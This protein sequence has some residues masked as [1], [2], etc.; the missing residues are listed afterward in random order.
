MHY[1]IIAVTV[2]VLAFHST[3]A[4]ADSRPGWA[5]KW[6][7]E[8]PAPWTEWQNSLQPKGEAVEI[9][10]S[11]NGTTDYRIIIP[12]SSTAQERR[13]ASELGLWLG[14]ITGAEFPLVTDETE[15]QAREL[16]VGK[17]NRRTPAILAKEI[18]SGLEGY[19]L[20]V[21]EDRLFFLGN[22]GPLNA[23]LAFLEEDLG[24]RWFAGAELNNE[25]REHT[26]A[27]E[28]DPWHTDGAIRFPRN[29]S[30]LASVVPRAKEP[31]IA[32]RRHTW[33]HYSYR[34]LG[35]RNRINGGFD[36]RHEYQ[37]DFVN[38]G[39]GVHTFHRLVPP[40]KYFESNPEYFSLVDGARR[41]RQ[42]QICLSNPEVAEVAAQTA[43]R[44]LRAAPPSHRMIGVSPM[45]WLGNCECENCREL[46]EATGAYSGVLLTFV[47]RVAEL[48]EKE[49]PDATIVTLAY[50]QSR[51][52]PETDI[53]MRDNVAVWLALDRN[54]TFDWP[55]HSFFDDKFSDR[56]VVQATRH[57]ATFSP[58]SE[59]ELFARWKEISP[60]LMLWM[61][62]TQYRNPHAPMPVWH[63]L[64]ENLQFAA[65][66]GVEMVYVQTPGSGAPNESMRAWI[67]AKLLWDP[68][69]DVD[70]LIQDFI[71]GGY[72]GAAAP[73]VAEYMQLLLHHAVN[74]TDFDLR[75]DWIYAIH[76]EAMFQ[77]GFVPKAREIL[78][79]SLARAEDADVRERLE[80]L[81]F[82]VVF[83]EAAQL[84]IQ[85]REG[86]TVP[87]L[88]AYA[89]VQEELTA[90]GEALEVDTTRFNGIAMGINFYDGDRRIQFIPNF[91]DAMDSHKTRR[92]SSTELAAS[93]WGTWRFRKDPENR[94]VDEKWFTQSVVGDETWQA[95]TVPSLLSQT[96][97]GRYL[98]FGWYHV[99]FNLDAHAAANAVDVLFEGVDE[100]A[101]IYVN[102]DYVGEHTLESEFVLGQEISVVDLFQRAFTIRVEPGQ[103]R[104]GVNHLFVR[105]HSSIGD[106]GIHRPVQIFLRK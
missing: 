56:S 78:H 81:K 48:I 104:E 12:K 96:E 70:A 3:V 47:N 52:P 42:A 31:A 44:A 73:E 72:Y 22:S 30:L 19:A 20:A 97:V 106:S 83:V 21:D 46:E 26:A 86:A 50:W 45:D 93:Q 6:M 60:R 85:M 67:T 74:Y 68:T 66:Q 33:W 102:G 2:L 51:K 1:S 63:P 11:E 101:W 58:L 105:K 49:V 16:S 43:I 69:L 9:A 80:R 82:G 18:Q 87:D 79:R 35:L 53:T 62:P 39:M 76:D 55:Y 14:K 89:R 77:H 7:E 84:F 61:Y 100:Q 71:W 29:P 92:L 38:G 23:V 13:A 27:L 25:W 36:R 41:W 91:I 95:V 98:G 34:P 32:I 103:L 54:S 88:A 5:A 57:R 8:P 28:A 59:T 17:T 10:L 37:R 75:R 94:G 99:T 65:Q 15:P 64:A 40:D 4:L 24:V 90:L